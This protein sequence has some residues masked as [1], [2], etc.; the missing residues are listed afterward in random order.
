MARFHAVNHTS[1]GLHCAHETH[2]EQ[3]L[4]EMQLAMHHILS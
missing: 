1:A 3:M 4:G 2:D